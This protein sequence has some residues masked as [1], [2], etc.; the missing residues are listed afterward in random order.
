MSPRRR[1]PKKGAGADAD[2]KLGES[3]SDLMKIGTVI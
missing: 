2:E 3:V 1:L